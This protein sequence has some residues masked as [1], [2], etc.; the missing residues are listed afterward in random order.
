[1]THGR[2]V[3]ADTAHIVVDARMAG[4]SG[5]GTY[6]SNLLPRLAACR[7]DWHLTVLGDADRLRA[8]PWPDEANVEFRECRSRIYTAREQVELFARAPRRPDLFW[9]PNYNIPLAYGGPLLVTVHDV[10]H[11]ALPEFA[12]GFHKQLYAQTMF[13]ATRRRATAILCDTAFTR[14]EYRRLVGKPP[15]ARGRT[16]SVSAT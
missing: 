3:I 6:I 8:L 13:A 1:M 12:A 11:L 4:D 16:S 7:P 14:D 2:S 10:A 9:S 5:I 15:C